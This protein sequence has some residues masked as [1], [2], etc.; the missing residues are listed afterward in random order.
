MLDGA[1][2]PREIHGGGVIKRRTIGREAEHPRHAMSW[3]TLAVLIVAAASSGCH[4]ESKVTQPLTPVRVAL[5][6]TF[7][8]EEGTR[9]SAS[10]EPY[11]EV[12]LAFKSGGYVESIARRK[13]SDG[14]MRGVQEGDY[15]KKGAV[16][17]V[18]RQKDYQDQLI[19]AEADLSR[20]QASYEQAKLSFDRANALFSTGSL[21]KPDYDSAQANYKAAAASVN[22]AKSGISQARIALDDCQLKSPI[23]GWIA[24]RNVDVGS[25]VGPSV[26]GFSILD[27]HL[28]KV[29]FGVPDT[30]I[31][32]VR[33][34][35]QLTIITDAL[36]QEFHGK[37]TSISP[38]ADPKSRVYSVEVTV[39][40]AKNLLKGGMIASLSVGGKR[41]PNPV[42]SVPLSSIVRAAGSQQGFSVFVIEPQGEKTIAHLRRVQLGDFHGNRMGIVSGVAVGEK[43]I[44]TGGPMVR[45]G[46]SVDVIP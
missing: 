19:H 45:D 3:V 22:D 31:E 8:G 12:D 28:V 34:G 18:V 4:N 33:L 11:A 27:T 37:V 9:Y 35:E 26:V 14:R 16:L 5:V 23:D 44:V 41:L 30:A 36:P 7:T 24:M 43:V 42:A 39:P 1:L 46:E 40:N 25:L 32:L 10:I 13:G 17:A 29:V 6:Q 38:A 15:V 2:R 21:T 20:S